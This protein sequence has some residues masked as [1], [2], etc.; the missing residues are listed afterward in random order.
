[1]PK[2]CLVYCRVSDPK[3]VGPG[4]Y[5]LDAQEALGRRYAEQAGLHVVEVIRDEG[6]T[7]RT[8]NRPGLRKLLEYT[9]DTPPAKIDTI[10]VQDTSRMGRDATDHLLFRRD[11]RVK[12]IELVAVTQ[13]NIDSSPEGTLVDTIMAGINQYQS[14]EK[15]R[16][17]SIAMQKKFDDGAWPG[18]APLGYVNVQKDGKR[19]VETDPDRFPLVRFAFTE[20]ATGTYSQEQLCEVLHAKGLRDR[21]GCRMQRG[22]LNL[23]L[24]NPFYWGLMRWHG[25]ERMGNYPPLVDRRTWDRCQAV[26]AAHSRYVSRSRKHAFLLTGLSVCAACGKH[27]THSVVAA[28]NNARYYHCD[29]RTRCPQPYVPADDLERRVATIMAGIRLSDDFIASVLDKVRAVWA[30]RTGMTD[31]E[32]SVLLRRKTQLEQQRETVEQKLLSGL[33]ADDAFQRHMPRITREL[34]DVTR[35]LDDLERSRRLDTDGLREL[36]LLARDIPKAYAKALPARK[37]QYAGFFFK[38]F[39]VRDRKIVENV[40]TDF[41]QVLLQGNHVRTKAIW[42][43]SLDAVR[44]LLRSLADGQ[45][46][47]EQRQHMRGHAARGLTRSVI[48]C[49]MRCEKRARGVYKR[50]RR[51][52]GCAVEWEGRTCGWTDRERR[53]TLTVKHHLWLPCAE[54]PS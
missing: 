27:H 46:L 38:E 32:R 21:R 39:R 26:T 52:R 11:L 44:T 17:V 8:T 19:W 49:E 18:W 4:H 3:Q 48:P 14:E 30:E 10:L 51:E 2:A 23:M 36:L 31:H 15:G 16:R 9:G 25:R 6:H 34:D 54:N 5:S 13:P 42:Y 29:S 45:W 53:R 37:R 47:A 41:A 7:G 22:T 43:P 12:G 33:L 24:A 35:T 20:Y 28:R 50:A 1:M 40:P